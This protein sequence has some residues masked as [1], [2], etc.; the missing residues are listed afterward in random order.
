MVSK[1]DKVYTHFNEVD[2]YLHQGFDIKVRGEIVNELMGAPCDIDIIDFGCGDGSISLQ[3]QSK[4]NKITLVDISE[5]M[6][7]RARLNMDPKY[8]DSIEFVLTDADSFFCN[9]QYDLVL[10]IGLLA[11]VDSITKTI[12]SFVNMLK[13]EGYC[14][15][16]ITDDSQLFSKFL[17]IYNSLLD[18]IT[19]QFGYI[20]NPLS[21]SK[22]VSIAENCG[23][24]YVDARQYSLTL[25]GFTSLLPDGIMYKYHSFIRNNSFL[26]S[27]GT[28][29][30]IKFQKK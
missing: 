22:I 25:P 26:S 15:I 20:R 28:D 3:F 12:E 7:N 30:I 16:Q 4:N 2:K 24:K 10:G 18:R 5:N 9:K 6:L 17:K 13:P 21:F 14:L 29:F 1:I 11:H 23:L 19:G 8:S 27:F